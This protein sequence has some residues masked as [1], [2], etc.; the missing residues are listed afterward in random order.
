MKPDCKPIAYCTRI[1]SKENLTFIESEVQRMLSEGI[2]E[3]SKSPWRAQV[4]VVRNSNKKRLVI[5]YSQTVNRFTLLD[6]YPLPR[7]EDIINNVS[8]DKYYS[9]LDLRSAYHQVPILASER[10]F[11]GFEALGRLYQ[12]RRLPFGVTN[13]VA[14]FQRVID[15]FIQRHKLK[16]VYAY[17]DDLTVTG[18]TACLLY[19]SPSPRDA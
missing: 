1:Y 8:R 5:D 18:A 16:K 10:P 13:G 7:I 15:S 6:A 19:T 4:L 2:I 14:A 12:Y 17:L 3:P 11:T 9:S